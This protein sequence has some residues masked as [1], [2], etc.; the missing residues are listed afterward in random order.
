MKIHGVTGLIDSAVHNF[1]ETSW[2][3]KI[4]QI[5]CTVS[6][7]SLIYYV[8]SRFMKT[9]KPPTQDPPRLNGRVATEPE[10]PVEQDLSSISSPQEI[11][12]A[13]SLL[14]QVLCNIFCHLNAEELAKVVPVCREWTALASSDEVSYRISF[15]S[16]LK[17]IDAD[18]W[19][20]HVDVKE[21]GLDFTGAKRLNR[22]AL[23]KALKP[24]SR[25][26]ENNKG[27]TIMIRPKGL[28]GNKVLQFAA[29]PK[30][31]NP[32]PIADIWSAILTELGD[33]EAEQTQVLFFTN[34]IFE[35]TRNHTADQHELDM[36]KIGHDCGIAIRKPGFRDFM[37][38]LALTY[39]SSSENPPTQL[40]SS[41]THTRLIEKWGDWHLTGGFAPGGLY[42]ECCP[43]YNSGFHIGVGGSG[44]SEDIGDKKH[45][46]LISRAIAFFGSCLF[47]AH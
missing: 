18:I 20:T 1:V 2:Q 43:D 30:M 26:V 5:L 6:S 31:G 44:S 12:V 24:L 40:Y 19:K 42:P 45:R 33:T 21:Y 16:W 23:T 46:D 41:L 22:L 14:P 37:A 34:S 9:D 17:E 32:V 27:I 8:A 15:P 38:F 28:T 11:Q 13:F 36:T 7:L 25:R 10:V 4:V 3:G 29:N 47:S 35:D 39:I